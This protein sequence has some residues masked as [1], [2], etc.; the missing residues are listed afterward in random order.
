MENSDGI[1]AVVGFVAIFGGIGGFLI[2]SKIKRKNAAWTGTVIDKKATETTSG[3][4]HS[5]RNNSRATIS[6][7][8]NRNAVNKHY[9][10][11]IKSDSGEE[12]SWPVGEGF[13][14]STQVGDRLTKNPGTETPTKNNV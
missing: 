12:F 6:I 10:L 4:V 1:L 11:V 2:Y 9:K 13:Y 7:G 5:G 14:E 3:P 8:A